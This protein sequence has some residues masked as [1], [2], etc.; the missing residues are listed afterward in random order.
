MTT[1]DPQT[2]QGSIAELADLLAA[3]GATL[4]LLALD[5][6]A[7]SVEL[8]V[9][10]AGV[11]CEECVLPPDRLHDTV[12]AT[13]TRTARRPV[14]VLLHDPRRTTAGAVGEPDGLRVEVLDPTGIGP[15]YGA[16][17]PGPAV[18]PLRGKTVAIRHDVLWASFDWTVD[19]WTR[20]FEAAGV[21]VLAWKRIQ[22]Q[23]GAEYEQAQAELEAMLAQAD[24]A[25]SGLGN[26]GSCTSWSVRDALTASARGLPCAAVATAHFE[27]LART[28]AAEGGRPGMR[29]MV[30]PYPYDTLA[31]DEVRAHAA[32]LFPELLAT[33]GATV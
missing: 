21:K 22:G 20:R 2:L 23:I 16:P 24:F 1:T 8:A 12:V 4:R 29:V 18:G 9:D 31:E 6:A 19:E 10:F 17:D 30:L 3:D 5:E 11:E 27:P 14:S 7:P 13:L 25:I 28:L 26:C 33:L 32:N 15:D